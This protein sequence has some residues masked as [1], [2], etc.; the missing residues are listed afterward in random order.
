MD[1]PNIGEKLPVF[2]YTM[3][4]MTHQ[5]KLSVLLQYFDYLWNAD[6]VACNSYCI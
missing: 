3:C 2:Y 6:Y 5:K 4:I 1:G